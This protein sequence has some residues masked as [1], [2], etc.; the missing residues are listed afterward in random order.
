VGGSPSAPLMPGAAGPAPPVSLGAPGPGEQGFITQQLFDARMKANDI[1]QEHLKQ[2]ITVAAGTL[3]LT[4]SFLK[5]VL[6][7]SGA[8]F[9]APQLIPTCWLAL[10]VSILFAI[11]CIAALI[12]NLDAPDLGIGTRKPWI[13]AFAAGAHIEIV[14]L[15]WLAVGPFIVGILSLALFGALNYRVLLAGKPEKSSEKALEN[16]YLVV[17]DPDHVGANG[18]KHS[19][20][21]IVDQRSGL[22]WDLYCHSNGSIEFRRVP[23]EGI[24]EQ[25]SQ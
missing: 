10:G 7:P 21:F 5:D 8:R 13:K 12:G 15:E 14:S 17:P 6:G 2:L 3:A 20:T 1:V 4:V 19:H 22:I 24:P 18:K 16:R 11:V 9:S 25:H 23:V